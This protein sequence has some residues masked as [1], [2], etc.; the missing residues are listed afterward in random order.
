MYIFIIFLHNIIRGDIL[1]NINCSLNCIYQKD[2]KCS[3]STISP[4]YISCK[5]DCVYYVDSSSENLY[6]KINE[7]S[8]VQ[9][10]KYIFS[11]TKKQ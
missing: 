9:R 6:D 5:S 8:I 2:G 7:N 4:A 3:Y 1:T 11:E 10:S